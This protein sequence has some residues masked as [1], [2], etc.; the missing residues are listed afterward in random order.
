M[1]TTAEIVQELEEAKK[2]IAT[3]ETQNYSL[4]ATIHDLRGNLEAQKKTLRVTELENAKVKATE[5]QIALDTLKNWLDK[6]Y[7]F[8]NAEDGQATITTPF[9]R[10]WYHATDNVNL[11]PMSQVP[12]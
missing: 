9:K 6:N 11:Y 1:K 8:V 12:K 4:T 10:I 3:L 7:S 5:A 2:Q